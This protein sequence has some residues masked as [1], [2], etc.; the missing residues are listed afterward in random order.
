LVINQNEYVYGKD[1]FLSTILIKKGTNYKMKIPFFLVVKYMIDK[2][3]MYYDLDKKKKYRKKI[4]YAINREFIKKNL[5]RNKIDSI[6]KKG[7]KIF[8]GKLVSNKVPLIIN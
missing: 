7:I 3:H 4:F 8:I 1:G 2:S 6:E 5:A